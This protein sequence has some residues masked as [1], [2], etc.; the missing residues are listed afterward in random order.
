M[1]IELYYDLVNIAITYMY[2]YHI[3]SYNTVYNIV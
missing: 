3:I 2:K 1:E